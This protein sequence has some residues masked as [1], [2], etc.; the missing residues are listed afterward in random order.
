MLLRPFNSYLQ[1]QDKCSRSFT[2]PPNRLEN[3]RTQRTGS[4]AWW[5]RT[6]DQGTRSE[7]EPCIH[8]SNE[9]VHFTNDEV[10]VHMAST[11]HYY[12]TLKVVKWATFQCYLS[13]GEW[14]QHALTDCIL[15]SMGHP[16]GNHRPMGQ[17]FQISTPNQNHCI[18][19]PLHHQVS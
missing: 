15:C 16:I 19:H 12:I 17:I 13:G 2:T 14:N 11:Y 9:G 1:T 8:A 7:F 3:W 18:Y 6:C 5:V 4:H 10:G